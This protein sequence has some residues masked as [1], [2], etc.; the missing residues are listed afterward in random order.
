VY[1]LGI[2]AVYNDSA[3]CLVQ[4]GRVIAAA[5]EERFTHVKHGKR[6]TPLSTCQ[7]PYYAIDYCLSETGIS[8]VD[9]DH[10]AYSFDP[11]LL[12]NKHSCN[13]T[14]RLPLKPCAHLLPAEWESAW[15]PL[16][17]SLNVNAPLH[18]SG[19]V[20]HHLQKR[21]HGAKIEGSYRWHFVEH[22]T[23]H[24]ASAFFV[25]PFDRAAVLTLDSRGEQATT[26]Y[27]L[28][29]GTCLKRLDQ[30]D[31]PHSLGLLYERVTAYLGFLPFS[32]EYKVMAL[33]SFGKPRYLDIFHDIINCYPNGK[34]TIADIDLEA[35]LGPRRMKGEPLE[36]RHFDIASSLQ[37]VLE[38]SVIEISHWLHRATQSDNLCMAGSV[39]LNCVM[40]V[41]LRDRAPFRNVWLQP[42]AGDAGTSI[43]AALWVDINERY[44][45]ART[46][47]MDHAFFG[48]AYDDET[49]E[50]FLRW[51]K[52]P[53]R[54]VASP[55]QAAADLLAEGK[56][57]G[58]YQSRLEYGPRT[59]GVRSMLA[60]PIPADIQER[61]DAIKDHEDF[62]PVA[63]VVLEEE[64]AEWFTYAEKSPF[65][66]FVCEVKPDKTDKIPA[67]RH[68]D[69]ST[70]M[71]TIN[72]DQHPHYYD[73]LKKF[74][75]WTGVPV[76]V[77]ASFNTRD[78][79]IVCT[80]RDAVEYFWSSPLDA[81]VIGSF[82]LEK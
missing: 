59:L 69:V 4:D 21:F 12:L 5:E 20:P 32:D 67:V 49:I 28:G 29:E 66:L 58:W 42:A 71:Q 40:N 1:T 2:N 34:Y 30:V 76:L 50:S 14:V 7:L 64:A 15:D 74:Y 13:D 17:L 51:S 41:R 16:F 46:A 23:A 78:E 24:A 73:L 77:N 38:D 55:S 62:Q 22:H 37:K 54:R 57:I 80:L 48:P 9:L 10:V 8:L 6:P 44:E 3:A 72:R 75:T 39:V 68:V 63:L 61:L 18:L 26:T 56:I 52:L 70:R 82:L 53:Y 36:E 27:S 35:A 45:P 31:M 60:S 25:S 11:Y 19:D 79:P 47:P 81:L 33:A 65:T 43:G